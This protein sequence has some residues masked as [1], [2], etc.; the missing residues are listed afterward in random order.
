MPD[1]PAQEQNQA[2]RWIHHDAQDNQTMIACY[3][4]IGVGPAVV[5]DGGAFT[6]AVSLR[7]FVRDLEAACEWLPGDTLNA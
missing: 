5:F 3:R 1:S 2:A 7:A 4:D 6:N